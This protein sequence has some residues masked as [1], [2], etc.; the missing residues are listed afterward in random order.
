[1]NIHDVFQRPLARA[2]SRARRVCCLLAC[3]LA[4][5]LPQTWL[6]APASAQNS[7]PGTQDLAAALLGNYVFTPPANAGYAQNDWH[8]VTLVRQGT[9]YRWTNKAGA[10]W[11]LV[12]DAANM[13]LR[14]GPDN[15]YY[16]QYPQLRDYDLV[17]VNGQL[18]GLRIGSD[19]FVRNPAVAL[20]AAG[21]AGSQAAAPIAVASTTKGP[22]VTSVEVASLA[23]APLGHYRQTGPLAWAEVPANGPIVFRF[24]E[25][26]RDEWS[27]YLVDRSR[28]VKVHVDLYQKKLYYADA[29]TPKE[30]ELYRI[31]SASSVPLQAAVA[32]APPAAPPA[33]GPVEA[34]N[35]LAQR[36]APILLYDRAAQPYGFPMSAQTF[37]EALVAKDP[38]LA[39]E[40]ARGISNTDMA[41]LSNGSIPT[42]YQVLTG[43]KQ[44]R[45][46]YW[47]FYGMQEACREADTFSS[48]TGRHHADWEAITVILTED[49]SRVAAVTFY[50]HNNHYTRI[51][52]PRD[53]PCT[54]DGTGR[55]NG[56]SG[57]ESE[58][59]RPVLYIEKISHGA[60][61]N[62][63]AAGPGGCGYHDGFRNPGTPAL[64][65]DANRRLVSLQG[66]SEP[67]ILAARAGK[68]GAWGPPDSTAKAEGAISTNPVAS[69]PTYDDRAC[70]GNATFTSKSSGCYKSECLAGDDQ[71]SQN[72]L[73]ECRPGFDNVGLTCNK[74]VLPWD[75]KVYGRLTGGNLYNYDYMLPSTDSGLSRRRV[76]GEPW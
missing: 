74:G 64:R 36:F 52:S 10:G 58:N 71:A 7:A 20:A 28:G 29:N 19:F 11:N 33:A 76:D 62:R 1:M 39:N 16:T 27:V 59:G 69:G 23:G 25:V 67:W 9:G 65:L 26:G 6:A 30:R 41:T 5:T 12:L 50:Q 18:T 4:A 34:V 2:C 21:A 72:C 37:Y 38:R 73:K 35:P 55:C 44:L 17:V 68:I 13:K 15:P 63:N 40:T 22:N 47:W 49:Q 31:T 24:E 32:A 42:Y 3:L 14:S 66:V 60:F 56:K 70:E 48:K 53:A 61:H 51:A 75:W 54:P 57:F 8:F 43:K 45:I 46:K